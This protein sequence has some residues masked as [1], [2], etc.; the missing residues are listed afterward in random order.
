MGPALRR[1]RLR[2][3]ACAKRPRLSSKGR[4]AQGR[5]A[6]SVR[7]RSIRHSPPV[8]E[9]IESRSAQIRPSAVAGEIEA[10]IIIERRAAPLEPGAD[11]GGVAEDEVDAVLAEQAGAG[12]PRPGDAARAAMLLPADQRGGAGRRGADRG[13]D[14]DDDLLVD[15]ERA[16]GGGAAPAAAPRS[17]PP[18]ASSSKAATPARIM[19]RAPSPAGIR[20]RA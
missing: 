11:A 15:G 17:P 1:G 7:N 18:K 9:R 14:A 4:A 10:A 8:R 20:D 16:L 3:A 5:A 6:R 13:G 19:A 2:A 12:D